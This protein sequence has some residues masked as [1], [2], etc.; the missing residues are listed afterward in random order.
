MFVKRWSDILLL[1]FP[2]NIHPIT[3]MLQIPIYISLWPQHYWGYSQP[4]INAHTHRSCEGDRCHYYVLSEP[5]CHFYGSGQE[6]TYYSR[7][8][9]PFRKEGTCAA[10]V[11]LNLML[12][13]A[14]YVTTV[15]WNA[16]HCSAVQN[17]AVQCSAVQRSTMLFSWESACRHRVSYVRSISQ[18]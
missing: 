7:W 3:I 11:F 15:Q 18:Y 6:C 2:S 8:Q 17:S 5:L 14:V 10:L 12:R 13:C 16:V 1:F 9:P 4:Y